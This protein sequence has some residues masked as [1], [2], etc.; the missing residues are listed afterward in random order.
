MA[1]DKWE[2]TNKTSFVNWRDVI[3]WHTKSVA[4]YSSSTY[5]NVSNNKITKT[6]YLH[7]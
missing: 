7:T 2:L 1:P 6:N 5:N 4:S 3:W